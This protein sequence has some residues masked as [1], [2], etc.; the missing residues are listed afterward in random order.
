MSNIPF[1]KQRLQVDLVAQIEHEIALG[2]GMSGDDFTCC[3]RA[4]RRLPAG[5]PTPRCPR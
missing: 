2:N 1:E 4:V 3:N 5:R